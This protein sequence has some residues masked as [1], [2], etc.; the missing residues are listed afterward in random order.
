MTIHPS[1]V[2]VQKNSLSSS[3]YGSTFLTFDLE[4][5]TKFK[6]LQQQQRDELDLFDREWLLNRTPD[7]NRTN[8]LFSVR[9]PTTRREI[10]HERARLHHNRETQR[11]AFLHKQQQT[12]EQF[13]ED[14]R[15]E[16]TLLRSG[17][18]Q[19]FTTDTL[20]R[21]K[22]CLKAK[23]TKKSRISFLPGGRTFMRSEDVKIGR[24]DRRMDRSE[25]GEVCWNLLDAENL[26]KV[27]EDTDRRFWR[28]KTEKEFQSKFND[29]RNVSVSGLKKVHKSGSQF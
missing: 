9:N 12:M 28:E 1:N 7:L 27:L 11:S 13:L 22:S 25:E 20:K 19:W 16:R 10:L 21:C 24:F 26:D 23:K 15:H 8:Q 17:D 2:A 29:P 14:R 6:I 3:G 5:E 4:T 18:Q